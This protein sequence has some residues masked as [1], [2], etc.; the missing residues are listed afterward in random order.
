VVVFSKKW[1][2]RHQ[3][4]LVRFANTPIG[5]AVFGIDRRPV[6]GISPG[7]VS[8]INGVDIGSKS[9]ICECVARCDDR[10]AHRLKKYGSPMW[11][12]AHFLDWLLLDRQG[13]IPNLGFATYYCASGNVQYYDGA[14]ISNYASYG[15][16]WSTLRASGG[17]N[18]FPAYAAAN[19]G[20]SCHPD[21]N[22]FAFLY[23]QVFQFNT[24]SIGPGVISAVSISTGQ[25]GVTTT[26]NL[27]WTSSNRD[28]C[29]VKYTGGG[30]SMIASY[31]DDFETTVFGYVPYSTY[32][33]GWTTPLTLSTSCIEKNGTTGLMMIVRGDMNNVTPTWYSGYAALVVELSHTDGTSSDPYLSVTYTYPVKINISDVWKDVS[34][35]QIN[36]GDSWKSLS[37]LNINIADVW[38]TVF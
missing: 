17:W 14:F 15:T 25:S 12:S 6:I 26:G 33:A 34:S 13:L 2:Q 23:R 7:G 28:M 24:S 30:S 27:I 32:S 9:L 35:I 1:F 36:I 20:I 38:K 37:E 10:Y 18:A 21:T 29:F 16:T 8:Y 31:F 3:L 5:R 11:L 4:K 19:T 22:K